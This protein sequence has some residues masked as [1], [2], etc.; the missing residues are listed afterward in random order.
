MTGDGGFLGVAEVLAAVGPA[1]RVLDVGCGSGRVTVALAE[2]GAQVTGMDTN[3]GQLG[4][5][6]KRASAAGVEVRAV[7]ADMDERLPFADGEFDAALSRLS[8]MIARDPEATV[9]ELGRVVEPGGS[10]VT[11]VWAEPSANPWFI[12]PRAGVAAALG[13]DRAGFARVFGRLG[14]L[15]EL[16]GLHRAA[17]LEQISGRVLSDVL[18]PATAAEHWDRLCAQIGHFRRLRESITPDEAQALQA[19]LE[20]R[21]ADYCEEGALALWRT[22]LLVTGQVAS[23]DA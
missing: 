17:G 3:A 9:R 4:E 15:T 8:L 16:E 7:E 22:M 14:D 13:P 23:E 18:R 5:L 11:A 12:E 2:R 21:L 1:M 10:V 19:A 20:R 6:A